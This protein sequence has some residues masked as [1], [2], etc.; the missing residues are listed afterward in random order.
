MSHKKNASCGCPVIALVFYL[1]L[2]MDARAGYVMKITQSP[3]GVLASGS[4][5]I[6]I[7]ELRPMGA[8]RTDGGIFS[9]IA[10]IGTPGSGIGYSGFSGP[11]SFGFGSL[12]VP[13]MFSGPSVLIRGDETRYLGLPVGYTSN[14]HLSE[15]I[16]FFAGENFLSLGLIIG[17]YEW[18]WGEGP[19]QYFRIEISQAA[20]SNPAA[21]TYFLLIFPL[22]YICRRGCLDKISRGEV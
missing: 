15:T 14:S 20:I 18:R 7:Y 9:A 21:I 19:G 5:S 10:A 13:T 3:D 11:T 2:V 22:L 17:H 4:G 16:L 1:V 12:K 6:D 8:W